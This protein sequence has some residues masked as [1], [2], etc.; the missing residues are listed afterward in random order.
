MKQDAIDEAVMGADKGQ[1][2]SGYQLGQDEERMPCI[3]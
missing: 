2:K 1:E 3:F